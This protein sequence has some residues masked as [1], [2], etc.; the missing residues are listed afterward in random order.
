MS[1]PD[2]LSWLGNVTTE[3]L[4][5]VGIDNPDT[6]QPP[7]A[8]LVDWAREYDVDLGRVHD[9]LVFLQS[10]PH[11]LL[12]PSPL[13]LLSYSP[14]RGSFQASFD[15]EFPP[16]LGQASFA[17]AGAWLAVVAAEAGEPPT[18]ADDWLAVTVDATGMRG[19]SV[20]VVAWAQYYAAILRQYGQEAMA[21]HGLSDFDQR[22]GSAV[23]RA[24]AHA[25]R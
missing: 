1:T 10:G 12:V 22:M 24:V 25:L 21:F 8:V 13:T 20:G 18:S 11:L 3:D 23:W 2:R 14:R 15:L 19:K 16:D 4:A 17:R 6:E 7:A 9:S 5:L